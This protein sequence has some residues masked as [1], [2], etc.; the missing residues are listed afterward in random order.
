MK[1]IVQHKRIR[2]QGGYSLIEVMIAAVLVGVAIVAVFQAVSNAT[3]INRR[4]FLTRRAYQY[5]EQVLE[6]PQHSYKGSYYVQACGDN[7]T[8]HLVPT[9]T[10]LVLD[11]VV[12]D[13]GKLDGPSDDLIGIVELIVEEL[14]SGGIDVTIDG[15]V[16]HNV[17]ARKLTA[18]MRYFDDGRE[19]RDSLETIVTL[20]NVN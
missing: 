10:P 3:R 8:G 17:P 2:R 18:R 4:E 7:P 5:L 13:E 12:L 9:G 15:V 14:A 16:C 20:V 6:D 11:T 1:T 19:W